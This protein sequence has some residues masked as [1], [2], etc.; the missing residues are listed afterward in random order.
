MP[1]PL[2]DRF[3]LKK[4]SDLRDRLEAPAGTPIIGAVGKLAKG[5]GFGLLLDT[6]ARLEAPAHVVVVGHGE[7]QSQL[8]KRA[9]DLGIQ[10][11][12][13][14]T[15]YQDEALPELYSLM[16]V[17]LFT[18]P[19][20]DWGH[21]AI[22]EAQGCGRPV[23]A[24]SYPGVEDLIEDGVSGRIVDSN[25]AALADAADSLINDT[26]GARQLGLAAADATAER[27]FA[28]L[29]QRSAFFLDKIL[30]E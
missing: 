14:W 8:E 11:R 9:H 26:E 7:L 16:D 21:R 28:P 2:E 3:R 25:P 27:R 20:S 22:S 29:G 4:D 13:H 15:G 5:R 19:G 17:V 24:A 6:A 10:G 1:V 23:V 30:A 18:K 12:V